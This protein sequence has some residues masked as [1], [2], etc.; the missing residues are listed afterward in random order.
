MYVST[1]DGKIEYVAASP[2]EVAGEMQ[3]LYADIAVCSIGKELLPATPNLL[4]QP[5]SPGLRIPC[6]ELWKGA[7]FSFDAA[8]SFG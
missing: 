5:K 6:I 2:Y 7:S 8:I 4:Q 3:K 1:P